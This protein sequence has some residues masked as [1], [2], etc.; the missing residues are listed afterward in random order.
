MDD[1][2]YDRLAE[3]LATILSVRHVMLARFEPDGAHARTLA[4][5]SRGRLI[6][7]F[8]YPLAGTPGEQ[9]T[10]HEPYYFS[11]VCQQFPDDTTLA[12][13]EVE[14]YIGMPIATP[15]GRALGWIA[16][17]DEGAIDTVSHIEEILR[18]TAVRIGAELARQEAEAL[19]RE[20][21][22]TIRRALKL[23]KS[24]NEALISADNEQQLLEEV[25]HLAVKIGGYRM[26]WVGYAQ[27]DESRSIVPQACSGFEEGFLARLQLSWSEHQANGR[28]PGGRTVRSGKPTVISDLTS[29]PACVSWG[30]MTLSQGYHGIICL[31]LKQGER[32]FGILTLYH[33]KGYPVRSDELQLLMHLADDLAFGIDILRTRLEQQRIQ[34][35]V[36]HIASGVSTRSGEE[37]LDHLTM[38]MAEALN[39]DLA[40]IARLDPD[41]PQRAHTLSLVMEGRHQTNFSYYLPGAPCEDVMKEIECIVHQDA[42]QRLPVE[43]R[44]MLHWV[45]GY[46]GR[47]LDNSAGEPFGLLGVMFREPLQGVGMV[48]NVL[49]IFA[50]G[51]AAEL[52]RQQDEAHI[53]YLAFRDPNTGLPNRVN[54]MRRLESALADTEPTRLALL[55]V[56]LDGFK[57]INDTQGH[58]V[59]DKVLHQVA[60]GFQQSLGD[61]ECI[62]RLGG[63][64]FVVMLN[65][66]EE[67]TAQDAAE[68][69]L[70]TLDAP[71]HID[72]QV[73]DISASIGIAFFP[74]D[75]DT[76]RELLKHTDIAMYEAKQQGG[77]YCFY[78]AQM[79]HALASRLSMAKRL[80]LAVA[81][82]TLSLNFQPQV[83]LATQ[84]LVGAEV[85]CRWHDSELGQVS[86]SD[87]IPLA[88]ERGLIKPLGSWVIDATCRQLAVWRAAG[89]SIPGKLAINVAS[90]Q[91]DDDELFK[92]LLN[93]CERH[94]IAPGQLGLELTESGFMS[95][96]EQAIAMTQSL[97]AMG[98]ELHIDDFGTGFSS[99]AYL[100]RFAADKIKIDISFVRDMLEDENDYAI[101]STI[102]AMARSLGLASIAEG[103]ETREQ[104]NALLKLGCQQ[105]QGYYYAK[106]L[107]A[108]EFSRQWLVRARKS[109]RG[110]GV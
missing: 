16:A 96:P 46:A 107:S 106:P 34:R 72:Q 58:D 47:R 67:A 27:Q 15:D 38:N 89:L 20:Q 71:L 75:A 95:D 104:A 12:G 97:K 68:R 83:E 76:A 39:A 29:D 99:L 81:E 90:K 74:D 25:C 24:C 2:F 55:F 88:E 87:F 8:V 59:G 10:G 109:C 44:D 33:H 36:M 4:M 78:K 60:K 103:V 40:F 7:N 1:D 84:R 93:A 91:F 35:A 48:S 14:T 51:V 98:F 17:M 52:E 49:K 73:F 69:L 31:P 100:K 6:E 41:D 30:S 80:A 21:L 42:H 22:F 53:R 9:L 18:I 5:W 85:L 70:A 63:D 37:F 26:A 11:D 32:T 82:G 65:P 43:G 57:D 13:L 92:T 61:N 102:I 23:L 110:L 79:G 54:F 105:A 94:R 66:A 45:Q 50:A 19:N 108:E 86:P 101:V 56:D 77:K 3:S 62:A 64:E 28:G